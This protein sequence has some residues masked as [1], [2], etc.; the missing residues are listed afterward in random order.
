[1]LIRS[2]LLLMLLGMNSLSLNSE[3]IAGDEEWHFIA[4]QHGVKFFWREDP[5][6][7]FVEIKAINNSGTFV[8]YEYDYSVFEGEEI[9]YA[10]K[11]KWIR[12]RRNDFNV[13]R[14]SKTFYSVTRVALTKLKVE[15]YR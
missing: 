13:I 12:L 3:T 11:N 5:S 14:V 6:W 2:L 8:N 10:G 4:I 15:M 7:H 1:M 9:S